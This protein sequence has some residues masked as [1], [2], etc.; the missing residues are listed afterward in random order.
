[1]WHAIAALD[2]LSQCSRKLCEV[3]G[4][5]LA[6]VRIDERFIVIDNRCPHRG[7]PLGAGPLA[8]NCLTCPWHGLTFDLESGECGDR[9]VGA[10]TR[11][12]T[13][14]A[15]GQ[16]WVDLTP[17]ETS[18]AS[19]IHR[20]LVRFGVP[21]HVGRFG[22]IAPIDCRRGDRVLLLTDRGEE[23]GE[24]LVSAT[25]LANKDDKR[26][27]GELLRVLTSDDRQRLAQQQAELP[28][29]LDC[30]RE[31]LVG[32]KAG[33]VV[34]DAELTFDDRTCILYHARE[35][36][37]ALGPLAVALSDLAGGRRVQFETW[38]P[39]VA[40]KVAA[41]AAPISS[42]QYGIETMRGPHERLKYD[43]RRVWECPL[44]HHRER[45]PGSVTSQFCPCQAKV[46]PIKQVPMK[47]VDDGP[48][49]VDG[50]VTPPR[51]ST[52]P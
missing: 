32:N 50:Q 2:E 10:L 16:L 11:W 49:R 20:Y 25:E 44:C 34:L 52:L 7:G 48:R 18:A 29:I 6:V 17:S 43:F 23:I 35:A 12:P 51:K 41:A 45:T 21:G 8:G 46:E 33:V 1:M 30:I 13:K 40:N 15:E 27:A 5:R 24:V 9:S 22:S 4:Q 36:T 3:A 37:E 39:A 26:P 38:Q 42:N 47:L 14:I 19:N 31:R 28:A